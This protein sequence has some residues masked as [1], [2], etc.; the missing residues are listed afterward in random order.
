[1]SYDQLLKKKPNELFDSDFRTALS[2]RAKGGKHLNEAKLELA[3]PPTKHCRS[4]SYQPPLQQQS[5]FSIRTLAGDS[6]AVVKTS[7]AKVLTAEKAL[8]PLRAAQVPKDTYPQYHPI[9]TKESITVTPTAIGSMAN[10]GLIEIK[11]PE[12]IGWRVVHY[13]LNWK[14]VTNDPFILDI[15]KGLK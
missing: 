4:Q 11:G 15:V 10:L 3:G 5:P 14:K 8:L 2:H 1:M 13:L 9:D 7:E 6:K 12:Q